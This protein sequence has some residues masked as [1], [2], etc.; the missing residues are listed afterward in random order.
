MFKEADL[1]LGVWIEA[2]KNNSIKFMVDLVDLALKHGYD[3]LQ[4]VWN[5][6]KPIF[7][8]GTAT[9][10]MIEDLLV[11]ADFSAQY[12]DEQLPD[13]YEFMFDKGLVLVRSED[14]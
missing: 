7:L 5:N 13:G 9:E 2:E 4:E 11:I 1:K 12:L 8:D 14:A 6:D 10:E 3:I